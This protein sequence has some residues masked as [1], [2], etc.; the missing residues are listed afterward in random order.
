[1]ERYKCITRAGNMLP[2][3]AGHP[4]RC[5]CLGAVAAG[6]IRKESTSLSNYLK[7]MLSLHRM[8]QRLV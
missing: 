4:K 2:A 1:M 7:N 8:A 5:A 6:V 3:V